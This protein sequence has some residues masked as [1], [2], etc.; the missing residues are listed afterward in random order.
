MD[1]EITDVRVH[2]TLR[3]L[4]YSY[5]FQVQCGCHLY[6]FGIMRK[7]FSYSSEDHENLRKYLRY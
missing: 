3:K 6:L 7:L 2:V 5:P 1:I 4:Y